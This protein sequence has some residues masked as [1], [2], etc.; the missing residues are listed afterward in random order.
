MLWTPIAS[1]PPRS[2][3]YLIYTKVGMAGD[4]TTI[5][6]FDGEDWPYLPDLACKSITHW[7]ELPDPPE[8]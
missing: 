4:H 6:W 2:G 3:A 5:S 1:P 8:K 7:M